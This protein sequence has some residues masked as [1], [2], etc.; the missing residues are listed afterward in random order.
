MKKII[1]ISLVAVAAGFSTTA[2]SA[3]EF[4]SAAEAKAMLE[5][6]VSAVKAN[7]AAALGQFA[8]G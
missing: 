7:K 4:G 5:K 1:A 3:G 2:I 6:A 8:K